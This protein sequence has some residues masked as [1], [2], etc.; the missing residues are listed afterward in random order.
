MY[1]VADFKYQLLCLK[2]IGVS[3]TEDKLKVIRHYV[4]KIR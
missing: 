1:I 2:L 4:E 3:I